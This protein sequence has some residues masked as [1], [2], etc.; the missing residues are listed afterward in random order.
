MKFYIFPVWGL[1]LFQTGWV[2]I[3]WGVLWIFKA[4]LFQ[5]PNKKN[6]NQALSLRVDT[7]SRYTVTAAVAKSECWT[8]LSPCSWIGW[9]L[10]Y[11]WSLSIHHHRNFSLCPFLRMY[12]SV[13][14]L[15]CSCCQGSISM[16]GS[17]YTTQPGV[18]LTE[19]WATHLT[20]PSSL[21]CCAIVAIAIC[22]L[23]CSSSFFTRTEILT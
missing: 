19:Q 18:T 3:T 7:F 11:E 17:A 10:E 2:N 8:L 15:S 5:T 14:P 13:F 12:F 22:S 20:H 4:P 16:L 6:N 23:G 1:P 9:I 21:M